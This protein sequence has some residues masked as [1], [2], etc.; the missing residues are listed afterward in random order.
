MAKK[1]FTRADREKGLTNDDFE[2]LEL[3]DF[4]LNHTHKKKMKVSSVSRP[5]S[6]PPSQHPTSLQALDILDIVIF[7]VLNIQSL[8]IS[9]LAM[10]FWGQ[11]NRPL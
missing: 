10:D 3:I 1:R 7:F 11:Q 4:K 8:N 9:P 6:P 5:T 2:A